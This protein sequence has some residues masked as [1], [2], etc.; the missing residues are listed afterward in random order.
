[1]NN[2]ENDSIPTNEKHYG[3]P[4]NPNIVRDNTPQK[5]LTSEWTRASFIIRVEQHEKIKDYAYTERLSIKETMEI[6]LNEFF[7]DKHNLLHRRKK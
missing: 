7:A 2:N 6:I 4:R 5:G 3:R 1:M